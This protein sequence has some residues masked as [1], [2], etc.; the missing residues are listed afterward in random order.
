MTLQELARPGTAVDVERA[1]ASPVFVLAPPRSFT[2]VVSA[3]LGQHPDLYGL[4]ELQSFCAET[5][6]EWW[7]VC[8]QA[9]Y[10]MVHGMLRA[11]AEIVYGEQTPE[12]VGEASGWLRRRL[13]W[14]TGMV[15]EELATRV[16]PRRVVEKS[17]STV[18]DVVFMQRV[19]AM[20]PNARFL[21]LVRHP[22]AQAGSVHAAINAAAQHGPV[23]QWL[24]RLGAYQAWVPGQAL[25]PDIPLAPEL[26]WLELNQNILEFLATVPAGQQRRVRG[27][28]VLADPVNGL[29]DVAA[30]LGIRTDDEALEATGHPETSPFSTFGPPGARLGNDANFLRNPRLRPER[31]TSRAS[32]AQAPTLVGLP[33]AV[34][35]LAGS[36]GYA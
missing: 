29:R 24:L 15:L 20:F 27:E 32:D 19:L 9:S 28:D 35:E 23:P 14:S 22:S 13:G 3:M 1:V 12:S 6:A 5:V 4:P 8:A 21:H 2:S 25:P 7:G 33:I 36:F 34:R 17:P 11:V 26:G 16:A 10:P 31:A 18:Y 30:W